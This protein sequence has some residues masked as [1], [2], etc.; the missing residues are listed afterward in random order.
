MSQPSRALL[1]A[2]ILLLVP[3]VTTLA[4]KGRLEGLVIP[5]SQALEEP[6]LR[7]SMVIEGWVMSNNGEGLF[8]LDDGSGQ[9]YVYIP[10]HVLRDTG[11]MQRKEPRIGAR[12]RVGGVYSREPLDRQ[13]HGI[14]VS[15]LERDVEEPRRQPS[16][17][18]PS[19][20]APAAEQ[21]EPA[22]AA[23]AVSRSITPD[24]SRDWVDKLSAA[25]IELLD[26]R[27][28]LQEAD[29]AY[30]RELKRAGK[31]SLM[32]PAVVARQERAEQ[33]VAD[34][35]AAVAPMVLEARKSGVPEDVL[36]LYER[37]TL[38]R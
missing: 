3:S 24:V 4:K 15:K 22:P 36:S 31:P 16:T 2:L 34:A 26:A 1:V 28:E 38:E 32:D 11:S 8:L 5:I 20:R 25:R 35:R 33:R 6:E 27:K 9:M 29:V 19:P 7:D 12:I 18:P 37:A 21:A 10:S 13:V 30:G 17:P 14:V 23:P